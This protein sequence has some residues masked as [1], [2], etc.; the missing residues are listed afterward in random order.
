MA[1]YTK[2]DQ[3]II[4]KIKDGA[5]TFSKIDGGSVYDEAKSIAMATG[6]DSFRVIDR[7]LQALRKRG[8]IEYTTKEKWRMS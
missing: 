1:D 2:M 8:V 5:N 4:E 6:G 7:R 3:L